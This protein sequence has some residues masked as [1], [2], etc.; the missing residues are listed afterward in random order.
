MNP[1]PGEWLTYNGKLSG[2]RYSELTH[3]NTTNVKNLVVKWSFSIPLW[4]QL[5]PDTPYYAMN[6]RYFGLE[7]TPLVADGIMYVTGPQQVSA[8][9]A[10]TGRR[11]LDVFTPADCRD[12]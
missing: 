8:L 4:R 5:L 7:S 9:D 3:I 12:W 10:L 1:K 11:D 6:M 2:N